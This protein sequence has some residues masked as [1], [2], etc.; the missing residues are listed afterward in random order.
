MEAR[1]STWRRTTNGTCHIWMWDILTTGGIEAEE[2][3]KMTFC[4]HE[5]SWLLES[6]AES[7]CYFCVTLRDVLCFGP[8]SPMCVKMPKWLCLECVGSVWGTEHS[9]F[10]LVLT[11]CVYVAMQNMRK[12]CLVLHCRYTRP[13]N[14]YNFYMSFL[15]YTLLPSWLQQVTFTCIAVQGNRVSAVLT[16]VLHELLP[17][18]A[19]VFVTSSWPT[20]SNSING[21]CHN[22]INQSRVPTAHWWT[23]LPLVGFFFP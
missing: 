22:T 13:C 11:S 10:C 21:G 16:A 7:S 18:Q 15:P 23:N 9:T 19:R 5:K 17:V 6:A 2:H 4:G 1:G 3:M 8:R 14:V 12:A 20:M